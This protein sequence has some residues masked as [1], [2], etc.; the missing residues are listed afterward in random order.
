MD[1][2]FFKLRKWTRKTGTLTTSQKIRKK[3]K[4]KKI[5]QYVPDSKAGN[6]ISFSVQ[7]PQNADAGDEPG[8]GRRRLRGKW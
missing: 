2:F 3:L 1:F 5:A 8:N 6:V 4:Q 7:S